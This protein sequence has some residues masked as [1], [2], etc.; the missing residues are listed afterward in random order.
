MEV[1]WIGEALDTAFSLLGKWGRWLN[2]K[3]RRTCFLVWS[4]AVLYW[5]I[6]D[7]RLHLYSQGFFCLISLGFHIYG[8]YNWKKKKVGELK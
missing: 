2:V 8:F 3:A 4:I 6:R 7:L 1:N 5:L